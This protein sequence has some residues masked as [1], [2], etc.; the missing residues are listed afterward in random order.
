LSILA[1]IEN[2]RSLGQT[3]LAQLIDPDFISGL[4]HLID[5]VQS[6]E[7]SG[8]DF[9]F[10]GGSLIEKSQQMDFLKVIKEISSVPT[11]LFPSAPNQINEHADGILFLS[12]ISGRNPEYLIGNQVLAAPILKELNL[13][14]LP[15]GYL[16]ISCGDKTTAEYISNTASI[17]YKKSGIAAT[18]ALAGQFLGLKLIYL[19]GGSGADKTVSPEMVERVK[20]SID[21][22]LIVG[23][24]I[25]TVE[26][27][28]LISNAGADLIVVGNEAEKNPNFIPEICEKMK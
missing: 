16:L 11:V 10:F 5:I 25:R 20:Q 28:I 17:P 9:F 22:P 2:A 13:E 24:G 1:E 26:D 12:L 19:D 18:T 21:I 27:A 4:D 14:V 8:V 7:K 15:T 6:G 3:L 23:G